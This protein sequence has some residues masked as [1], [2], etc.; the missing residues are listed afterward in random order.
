MLNTFR[1]KQTCLPRKRTKYFPG[2][3]YDSAKHWA[4]LFSLVVLICCLRAEKYAI[5]RFFELGHLKTKTNRR[6]SQV[7][8]Y[9]FPVLVYKCCVVSFSM[10]K[11]QVNIKTHPKDKYH[12]FHCKPYHQ[13]VIGDSTYGQASSEKKP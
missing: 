5:N 1:P 10:L 11:N 7:T 3:K 12:D 4:G 8:F 2:L 6:V 9:L 13:P